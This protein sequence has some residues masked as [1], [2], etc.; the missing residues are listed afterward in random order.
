MLNMFKIIPSLPYAMVLKLL[1]KKVW[2]VCERANE[3][4][5]NGAAFFKYAV[6]NDDGINVYY[7]I[8]KGSSDYQF[9]RQYPNIIEFG[10]YGKWKLIPKTTQIPFTIHH[11]TNPSNAI[12]TTN[13]KIIPITAPILIFILVLQH[14]I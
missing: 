1:Q 4:C 10:K 14:L 12:A 5:D 6:N 7:A 13:A 2:L 3:A 8:K 9:I 11:H